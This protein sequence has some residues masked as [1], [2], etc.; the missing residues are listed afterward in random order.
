MSDKAKIVV[1]GIAV[2]ISLLTV[3]V[4]AWILIDQVTG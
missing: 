3:I 1:L 2:A 4:A